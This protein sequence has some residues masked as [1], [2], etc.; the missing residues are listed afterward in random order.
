VKTWHLA[1][2]L[3]LGAL[4]LG[5][6]AYYLGVVRHAHVKALLGYR[7]GDTVLYHNTPYA[8]SSV[9]DSAIE[10][11]SQVTYYSLRSSDGVILPHISERDIALRS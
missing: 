6:A 11:G 2:G 3:G 5:G 1:A 10:N 9:D 8:I 4:A 7:V